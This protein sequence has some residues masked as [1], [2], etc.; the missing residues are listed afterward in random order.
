MESNKLTDSRYGASAAMR[1][2]YAVRG[3]LE[4]ALNQFRADSND[5]QISARDECV[6]RKARRTEGPP[7]L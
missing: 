5:A 6:S 3:K 7:S 2:A 1:L 4:K